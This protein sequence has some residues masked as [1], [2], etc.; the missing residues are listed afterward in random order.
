MRTY[1]CNWAKAC[2]A[3]SECP[4]PLPRVL[5]TLPQGRAGGEAGCWLS[6]VTRRLGPHLPRAAS[7]ILGA[8]NPCPQVDTPADKPSRGQDLWI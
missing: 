7:R 5:A 1:R 2:H 3:L 6:S 4:C 8:P